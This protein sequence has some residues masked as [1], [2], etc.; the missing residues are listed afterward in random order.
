MKRFANVLR[1]ADGEFVKTEDEDATEGSMSSDNP[2]PADL[3]LDHGPE[4]ENLDL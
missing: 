3:T 2:D 4:N 1:N